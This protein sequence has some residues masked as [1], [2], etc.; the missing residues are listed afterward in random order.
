MRRGIRAAAVAATRRS[1][2]AGPFSPPASTVSITFPSVVVF[3]LDD[4]HIRRGLVGSNASRAYFAFTQGATTYGTDTTHEGAGADCTAWNTSLSGATRIAVSLSSGAH[5]GAEWA[6][7]VESALSGAGVTGVSRV[8]ATVTIDGGSDLAL[9]PAMTYDTSA[10]GL[11]G[12]QRRSYGPGFDLSEGA[13]G[14]T[15]SVHA[16]APATAGR[17]LAVVMRA[18]GANAVR[19][20]IADGP[21]YSTTPAAFSNGVEGSSSIGTDSELRVLRLAEP[22]AYASATDKWISF[23]GV[24][25]GNP[26]LRYRA[27]AS[28]PEGRGDLPSGEQLLF[29]TAESDPTVAIYS[30]GAYTHGSEAGPYSIYSFVGFVYETPTAGEYAG[31]GDIVTAVGKHGASAAAPTATIAADMDAETFA[32]RHPIPWDCRVTD[33]DVDVAASAVDEDLGLSLYAFGDV[34]A[35]SVLGAT[36]LYAST[37]FGVAGTG[38]QRHTPA[39]PIDVPAGTILG[40]EFNAGNLDGTTPTDTISVNY[41]PDGGGQQAWLTAWVDD[42]RAWND[43]DPNGG[44]GYGVETEYRTRSSVGGGMPEGDPSPTWPDPFVVD[45]SDDNSVRNHLQHLVHLARAGMVAA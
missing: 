42:G 38:T 32:M 45:A 27:H 8:G 36:L 44:G 39:T 17:V 35:P 29:S 40:V 41:H 6:A 2:N 16:T 25:G 5:T 3:P 22:Q 7:A 1:D 13:M 31:R 43:M 30:G 21:A 11:W 24:A 18:T 37:G 12:M 10:R 4:F 33:I 9:A 19:L 28:D 15:G 20:G 14:G 23:R 26:S 34:V